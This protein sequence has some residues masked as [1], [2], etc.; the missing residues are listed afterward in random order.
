[1]RLWHFWQLRGCF[2]LEGFVNGGFM[3][4]WAPVPECHPLPLLREHQGLTLPG[5]AGAQIPR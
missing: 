1:M 4:R 5:A 3:A 2:H